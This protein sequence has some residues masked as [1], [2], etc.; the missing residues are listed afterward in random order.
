MSDRIRPISGG[1]RRRRR[2]CWAGMLVGAT[3]ASAATGA[4]GPAQ[5]NGSPTSSDSSAATGAPLH[6]P[7][8]RLRK[9][10]LPDPNRLTDNR[11]R[12]PPP[13]RRVKPVRRVTPPALPPRAPPIRPRTPGTTTKPQ[14]E[15]D[16][17]PTASAPP[18]VAR[19][20]TDRRRP[21]PSRP[22]TTASPAP[23]DAATP[24]TTTEIT[25]ATDV[26]PTTGWPRT[27][28]FQGRARRRRRVSPSPTPGWRTSQGRRLSWSSGPK[29]RPSRRRPEHSTGPGGSAS[30][31]LTQHPV[32][33]RRASTRPR[34][35]SAGDCQASVQAA[36]LAARVATLQAPASRRPLQPSLIN[37]LGSIAFAVLD[38]VYAA[39]RRARPP[40]PA[41]ILRDGRVGRRCRS[42]AATGRPVRAGTGTSRPARSRPRASSTSST[43][44]RAVAG[45]YSY[46]AATLAERTNSIVVAPSLSSNL[47]DCRAGLQPRRRGAAARRRRPVHRG[48]GGADPTAARPGLR[49]RRPGAAA[50]ASSSRGTPRAAA[51][52]WARR[53]TSPTTPRRTARRSTLVG[54]LLFDS[55]PALPRRHRGRR[56]R[57]AARRPAR[58]EHRCGRRASGT[59][60]DDLNTG[61]GRGAEARNRFNG[62]QLIGGLHSD[63]FQTSRIRS[64]KRS[65]TC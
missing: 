38:F 57:Q 63:A 18:P 5:R 26:V 10:P 3:A 1:S 20:C 8:P 64:S 56:D 60:T 62:V 30:D 17:Q 37:V 47:F 4:P 55:G 35:R 48:P 61:A 23:A 13:N 50:D 49:R 32:Q 28:A 58:A 19:A 43:G 31:A 53:A 25:P 45:M 24:P 29:P 16:T 7:A 34:R 15:S 36:L 39:G 52:R 9:R 2:A 33:T 59:S 46:T 14:P 22:E 51:W 6:L 21:R 11:I 42:T 54:V 44:S 12:I 27:S 65:S 40:F 41:G